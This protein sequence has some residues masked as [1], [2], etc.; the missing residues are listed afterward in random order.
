MSDK[1]VCPVCGEIK[2][3]YT[4]ASGETVLKICKKCYQQYHQIETPEYTIEK[5]VIFL[6]PELI[7]NHSPLTTLIIRAPAKE[8]FLPLGISI[9][10]GEGEKE[11]GEVEVVRKEEIDWNV[12]VGSEPIEDVKAKGL[13]HVLAA[14]FA[15]DNAVVTAKELANYLAEMARNPELEGYL[16]RFAEVNE[17]AARKV[18]NELAEMG[19]VKKEAKKGERGANIY[20][21]FAA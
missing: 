6:F 19:I 9:K 21:Y 13:A 8:A 14:K 5:G 17:D 16:D 20:D 11:R 1:G 4:V 7:M 12:L 15:E 10:K 2:E 3:L 18:L